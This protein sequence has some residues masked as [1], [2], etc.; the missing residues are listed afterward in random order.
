[1]EDAEDYLK[2][3]QSLVNAVMQDDQEALEAFH[4]DRK[5]RNDFWAI[6]KK[7]RDEFQDDHAQFDAYVFEAWVEKKYGIKLNFV[8]GSIGGDYKIVDEQKYIVYLLKFQ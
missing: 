3:V 5:R 1:M 6:L 2:R 4:S 7:L 8:Q